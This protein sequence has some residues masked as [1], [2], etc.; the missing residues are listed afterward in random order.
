M[1]FEQ[2][3]CVSRRSRHAVPGLT[4]RECDGSEQPSKLQG[5]AVP[6]RSRFEPFRW[7]GLLTGFVVLLWATGVEATPIGTDWTTVSST[8][9]AGTLDGVSV[10]VEGLARQSGSDVLVSLRNLSGPSYS[11]APLPSA[12]TITYG[13]GV[14]NWTATFGEA[15]PDL[16]LYLYSWRGSISSGSADV[17]S[18]TF[19]RP[20]TVLSGLEDASISGNTITLDD[21]PTSFH[22][23]IIQFTG[24]VSMV[25]VSVTAP[26]SPFSSDQGLTF[27]A[28]ATIVPEPS[29]GVLTLLGLAALWLRRRRA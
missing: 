10:S 24:P 4:G 3:A 14:S 19:D 20:F 6:A 26:A 22:Q 29:T 9:A 15:I 12:E 18:Y 16:R 21:V 13:G 17:F 8:T 7:A 11:G 1:S 5:R 28:E 2:R 25:S 27:G 23:G